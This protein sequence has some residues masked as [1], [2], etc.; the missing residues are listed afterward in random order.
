MSK[1]R[2]RTWKNK[3]GKKSFCWDA[4]F[5]DT[6]GERIRKGGFKTKAEAEDYIDKIRLVPGSAT[7]NKKAK[8]L[9]LVDACNNYIKCHAEVY[10]KKSTCADYKGYLA[11]HIKPFFKNNKLSDIT[12]TTIENFI[13]SKS[14]DN[15]SGA[16]LN[17]L[18]VFLKAVFQ[19]MFNDDIISRNPMTKI[20]KLTVVSKKFEV[21]DSKEVDILINTAHKHFPEYYPLIFT[22]LATGMRQ[23]ELF[24]LQ[25][26]KIDWFNR[27]ILIDS[28]YTKYHLTSPKSNKSRVIDMT[29]G[30]VQV[31]Q[32]WKANCPTSDKD[33]VFP[34]A[35]G[36]YHNPA[37]LNRRVFQP[38][39][40]KAGI[41]KI[42]FHDLRHTYT[43]LL[44][45]ENK[46]PSYIQSQLGHSTINMTMDTY[47]HILP[48][49]R[50]Q[51]VNA[52]DS[53]LKP[54]GT[55]LAQNGKILKFPNPRNP[56]Q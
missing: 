19:K 38:L 48:T 12:K 8:N 51:C 14:D 1:V 37:N 55:K 26:K 54:V 2:R 10:C 47:G 3:D 11:N 16:T 15:V 56:H 21:L 32:E 22:A 50:E 28:N 9:T 7:Y 20:K 41:K 40:E 45:A 5:K 42:R 17:H 33:L 6:S 29:E 23:G 31:L 44:I 49:V 4:D 52:L 35:A 34:N 25:W 18:L 27:T 36:N 53:I 46:Q 39:I 30:L 24:A 13:R 43:S